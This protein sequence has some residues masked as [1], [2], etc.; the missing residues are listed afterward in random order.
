MEQE[1]LASDALLRKFSLSCMDK[2][3]AS[4]ALECPGSFSFSLSDHIDV[5]SLGD[6]G[7]S[8]TTEVMSALG[9]WISNLGTIS[10]TKIFATS[11]YPASFWASQSRVAAAPP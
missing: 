11:C 6:K 1:L 4:Q 9:C 2:A 3:R 8:C 7:F 5:T 10:R